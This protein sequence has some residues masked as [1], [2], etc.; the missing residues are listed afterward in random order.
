MGSLAWTQQSPSGTAPDYSGGLAGADYDPNTNLVFIHTESYGQFVSYNFATNTYQMLA[1]SQHTDYHMS[2]VI[3]PKAKLFILWGGDTSNG[4]GV[5]QV[6]ISG[7]DPTYSTTNITSQVTGCG[8]TTT[9]MNPGLA[10]DP[11]QDRVVIWA[12]GNTVYLFNPATKSCTSVTYSGG[13][14]AQQT[15]GTFGRFRYF[16]ALGVF[17][18]VNDAGQNAYTLRLTAPSM[19]SSQDFQNRCSASGVIVCDGFDSS[20]AIPQ[21]TCADSISGAYP[22]CSDSTSTYMAVDTTTYRSGGGSML[23][24]IPGMAGSN[25]TGYYRRLFASSQGTDATGATAFGQNSDFYIQY[26]QRMDAAYVTNQWPMAGGGTTYWKQQI[27]SNDA[28]TCNSEEITTVNDYNEGYPLT[29]SDCGATPF[30]KTVS[31]VLYNEFTQSLLTGSGASGY[32]CLYSSSQPNSNCF[33][34]SAVENA[35]VTYYYHV[36]IGTWGSP[37]SLVEASVSTP[38]SLPYKQWLYMN[39]L[40]LDE[41]SP[42]SA[43]FDMVTLLAYW[44]D[45]TNTVSAGPTS[46]TWYDEL[47]V[48]S[49]PIAAPQTLPAA[50]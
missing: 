5:A 17:A 35:W 31:G 15:N 26:A 20:T 3:D 45:R 6:D 40:T 28:S 22:N 44:T 25:S 21:R 2:V 14:A 7:N 37:N 12:G 1:S 30:Q 13:P 36:H 11:I 19:T 34:Y 43:G 32:N 9:A 47:I 16:P 38:T 29:Y 33:D 27:I 8:S 39:N 4:G 46:H 42:G 10:Y 23:A 50:P 18:L 48:S 49:Q 41:N 24:T